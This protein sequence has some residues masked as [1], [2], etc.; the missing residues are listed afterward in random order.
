MNL[1][2]FLTSG[3]AHAPTEAQRSRALI[4][5]AAEETRVRWLDSL[6]VDQT[7]AW[8]NIG[9]RDLGVLEGMTTMLGIAG[10]A[11]VYDAR[12]V[13]TPDLR[14]IRGAVSAAG[15]CLQTG[16]VVTL[17]DAQAFSS[18]ANRARSILEV[19]SVDAIVHAAT[20]IRETV[21]I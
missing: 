4:V 11:H 3:A 19:A 14:I 12:N 8:M 1:R 16:G 6:M 20:T 17:A 9:V 5:K 15:Q 7:R 13:D 2:N 18:A 10:F 21:G